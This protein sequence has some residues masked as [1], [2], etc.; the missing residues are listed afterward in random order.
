MRG[1]VS[2]DPVPASGT[3]G[4]EAEAADAPEGRDMTARS[5]QQETKRSMDFISGITGNLGGNFTDIPD[6]GTLVRRSAPPHLN[7]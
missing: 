3:C 1:N 7:V 5:S 2:E 6:R 4:P